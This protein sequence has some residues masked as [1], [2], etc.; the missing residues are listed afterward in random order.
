MEVSDT[1]GRIAGEARPG[2]FVHVIWMDEFQDRPVN[3]SDLSI[4]RSMSLTLR[5]CSGTDPKHSRL[6]VGAEGAY[7]KDQ[8]QALVANPT[9][10][11]HA[12]DPQTAEFASSLVG[13]MTPP[14]RRLIAP[15]EDIWE[16]LGLGESPVHRFVFAAR[17]GP[18]RAAQRFYERFANRRSQ[19]SATP[20][21]SVAASRSPAARISSVWLSLKGNAMRNEQQRPSMFENIPGDVEPA[22]PVCKGPVDL[23]P[24][25]YQM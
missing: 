12:C 22:L 3:G 21:S 24:P 1:E 19:A 6:V 25:L 7:G 8:A 16:A 13:K 20:L 17:G 4:H 5:C 23:R 11:F 14:L 15:T 2:D 18:P 9:K 10:I